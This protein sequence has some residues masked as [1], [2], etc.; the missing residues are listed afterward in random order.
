[1]RITC[2]FLYRSLLPKRL[3]VVD[4]DVVVVVVVDDVDVVVVV[5]VGDD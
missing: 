2:I 1:M 4:G 5:V 3:V